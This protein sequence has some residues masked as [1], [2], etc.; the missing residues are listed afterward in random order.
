M[1]ASPGQLR[2]AAD[3]C[4]AQ[5]WVSLI[6]ATLRS[7]CP[8]RKP[9]T[10]NGDRES[11]IL[12]PDE[13][14]LQVDLVL[15]DRTVPVA[16]YVGGRDPWPVPTANPKQLTEASESVD[17]SFDER[18]LQVDLVRLDRAV[19]VARCVGSRSPCASAPAQ[20]P[21]S[22]IAEASGPQLHRPSVACWALSLG[23]RGAGRP[24]D[25]KAGDADALAP[26]RF[27]WELIC[28]DAS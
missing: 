3:G 23:S 22:Q 16:G 1:R 5:D 18:S 7:T 21:A 15:P 20:C 8:Y 10:A 26:R 28:G 14:S 6:S 9:K 17:S 25:C 2:V 19:A 13:R 11:A 4:S 24:E 12:A 27:P